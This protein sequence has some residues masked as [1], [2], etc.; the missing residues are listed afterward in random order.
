[1]KSVVAGLLLASFSLA[2]GVVHAQALVEYV[3]PEL[4]EV[5]Q[6]LALT[7][8][9]TSA[10]DAALSGQ[11]QGLVATVQVDAGDRVK[12]GQALLTLDSTLAELALRRSAAAVQEAETRLA[13][14][15]RLRDEARP[16]AQN[17]SLPQS[18]YAT[19]QG[20]AELADAVLTRLRA[21]HAEQVELLARHQL[22][23]PFDGVIRQRLAAPG[24]WIT[25]GQAVFELVATDDLRIEVQVPQQSYAA[26]RDVQ[27]AT[28]V[29]DAL[30]GQSLSGQVDARV[31]A[32]NAQA[33]SF[34]VRVVLDDAHADVVPGMSA[35]VRFALPGSDQAVVIPRDAL[36][37][38]PDGSSMVWLIDGDSKVQRRPV[39]VGAQRGERVVVAQGLAAGDQVIVR[40]NE[41]LRPGQAVQAR[42][43]SAP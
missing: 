42:P 9:V 18:E 10:S 22:K 33:R 19:R 15:R 8:T 12:A 24:E 14:A 28:V 26:L 23:A 37:R 35:R 7:G 43:Y 30:P 36:V 21:E 32:L 40:G 5:G 34:L 17:G 20:D 2:V 13:E 41:T 31:A 29:I 6:E 25:P 39:V 11:I 3:Q 1:M 4:A 16:L 38:F 27:N